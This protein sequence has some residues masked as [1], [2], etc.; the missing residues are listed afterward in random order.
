MAAPG[1]RGART[2]R[3]AWI[4]GRPGPERPPAASALPPAPD[5]G[6]HAGRAVATGRCVAPWRAWSVGVLWP[7]DAGQV[8]GLPRPPTAEGEAPGW[9]PPRRP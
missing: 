1:A 8:S 4:A 5:V 9:L 3:G 7:C 2:A 6:D